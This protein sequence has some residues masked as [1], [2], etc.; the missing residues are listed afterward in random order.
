MVSVSGTFRKYATGSVREK[1]AGGKAGVGT[2]VSILAGSILLALL[3]SQAGVTGGVVLIAMIIGVPMI[4]AIFIF[5]SAGIVLLLT[6]AYAIMRLLMLGVNFPLGTLMDGLEMLL[7]VNLLV[8][9]KRNKDWHTLKGP[10][11]TIILVWIGYNIFELVNPAAQSR[12]AWLYTIRTVAIIMLTYFVFLYN[13]NSIK[14]LRLVIKVWLLFSLVAALYAFKQ[15]YVGF[16]AAEDA[17]LH[18][19]PRIENLLFIA[20]HWRKFSIF[21][22]PVTFSYNMVVSSLLCI[23]LIT[24]PL[25]TWKKVVLGIMVLA[26]L[27]AMLFSGTRGAYVLVPAAMLL[28]AILKF[29]KAVL[30]FSIAAGLF[31]AFLIVVPTSNPNI[32][33]FQ[34]AFK[35]SE[36]ASYMVR[37]NNQK[38]I[39]PYIWAHPIG[40]GLGATGIWGQRF[41]PYSYLA[42]FPPDSGYVRVAVELGWVGLFLFCLLM[43]TILKA[44]IVNYYRIK[45]PELKS[46]CLSMVLVVFAFN[47][48]NFPQEALVQYPSNLLFYLVVAIIGVSYKLDQKKRADAS[49]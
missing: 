25:A 2:I 33:R 11:S 14:L 18:S 34:T 16:S 32:V 1:Y 40:G 17:Y 46:Y 12:L 39:Q 19:D 22:D 31:I 23:G 37:K 38:K 44:G 5:P 47:I 6:G 35:P 42:N 43:F 28:F 48:G 49:R 36:D 21:S 30:M 10:V 45:D 27:D 3:V 24:G 26:F 29:N 9:L 13:I 41:A 20:G 15:E 8:Q 7:V 4:A